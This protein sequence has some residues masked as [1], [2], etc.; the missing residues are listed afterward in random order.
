M[1]KKFKFKL[2]GLLKLRKFNEEK[3]KVELGELISEEQK[4]IDRIAEIGDELSLGYEMQ[5]EAFLD[6]S[7][8]KDTYFYPYFFEGKRKDRE[9][10]ETMLYSVRKKIEQKRT[11]LAE[12][13]GNV[14]IMESLK[15]NKFD[16]YKKE[17]N[18]KE[19]NDIEEN[20]IMS[21][22]KKRKAL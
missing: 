3:I 8:G 11:E 20:T 4:I 19:F 9:R 15:E 14:K 21:F 12:A 18:K 16:E 17:K 10:C 22:S 1:G 13:M 5:N 7:K 2:E 6:S